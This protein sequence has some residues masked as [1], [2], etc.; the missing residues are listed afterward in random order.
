MTKITEYKD[1]VVKTN[2]NTDVAIAN[3]K[4]TKMNFGVLTEEEATEEAIYYINKYYL[5]RITYQTYNTHTVIRRNHRDIS[6]T[7]SVKRKS[8]VRQGLLW[9]S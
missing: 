2:Y 6:I 3:I 4:G 9:K 5:K 1:W 7:T 8:K